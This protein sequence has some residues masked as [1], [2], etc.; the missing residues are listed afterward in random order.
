MDP[1]CVF[2]KYYT[3]HKRLSHCTHNENDP[4]EEHLYCDYCNHYQ[5]LF[6]KTVNCVDC[7]A[8]IVVKSRSRKLRC[9]SCQKIHNNINKR[10]WRN[11]NKNVKV[12]QEL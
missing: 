8:E 5:K 7:G 6:Y 4:A 1:M 11:S 3:E 2:C 9:D 12:M 10:N